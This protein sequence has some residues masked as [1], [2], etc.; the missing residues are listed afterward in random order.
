MRQEVKLADLQ[1]QYQTI[2]NEVLQAIDTTLSG[3]ELYL[4]PNV[5][6]FEREF[7][8][9][10]GTAE[11][12]GVASGTDALY[13][14]LRVCDIGP[15][16]EV[17][18]VANTFI[19]TAEAIVMVGAK[20][21]FV[22][23]EPE[24]A[25]MDPKQVDAAITSRTCALLPV[26]LHGQAA[27]MYPLQMIADKYGLLMIEDAS[28]AQGASYEGHRVGGLSDIGAFGFHFSKNLGAYGEAGMVT[29]NNRTFAERV[30]LLRDHGSTD[31]YYHETLGTNSYLDEVHAA[32]LRI[33]LRKLDEWNQ[34]RRFH[35]EDYANQLRGCVTLPYERP[36]TEQVYHAYVIEADDRDGLRAALAAQDVQTGIHYPLP[37]HLQPACASFACARGSLPVTE[38]LASRILSLPMFPELTRSEIN[39]VCT[40]IHNSLSLGASGPAEEKS[41]PSQIT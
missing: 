37:L 39:R 27:D 18:T 33:K 17:I 8:D 24:T 14:A 34:L 11:A 25:T 28:Q 35:A 41:M 23:V 15:G 4:G 29:T 30:R 19:S 32:M 20:P 36:G 10:C 3:M 1:R 5:R 38:R 12:V 6:L 22:D 26:H 7:A 31:R 40:C 13:M 2:R 16:D 9:Y 21:V